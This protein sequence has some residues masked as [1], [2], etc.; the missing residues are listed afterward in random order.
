M[1]EQKA[2]TELSP[3]QQEAKE[4]IIAWYEVLQELDWDDTDGTE[5]RT[6][7][8]PRPIF[9]LHG[10]AGTGKT[11]TIRNII[12]ALG[13]NAGF[14]AYTGKAALVMQRQG[15]SAQTLHSLLYKPVPPDKKKCE[16]LFK[17]IK[18]EKSADAK[19]RLQ[20]ELK[21]AQQFTFEL[22]QI[23]ESAFEDMDLLVV[24]ECSMVDE[25]MLAD[26]LTFETPVLALGDPGQLPPVKGTGALVEPP[27]DALLTEI[28]RQAEGN[29]I[30]EYATCARKGIYIPYGE[31]GG[32]ARIRR[33]EIT[34][35]HVMACDQMLTG[36]N[37]SRQAIN[38]RYRQLKGF[39][40]RY[41]VEGE[42][43]ICLKNN[44][45]HGIF[46]GM[47]AEVLS[48]GDEYDAAI[49][50]KLK[51]ENDREI[52]VP[53]LRAYFDAYE[54]KEA[55]GAV[56]WWDLRDNEQFDFGYCI[57]V[58]K[59]QGSQWDQVLVMDDG[60]LKWDK[61]QRN[62][63]LYTAITRAAESVIIADYS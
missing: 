41:P 33:N 12:S 25:E 11:T 20:Q 46:N 27:V 42:K 62:R 58:H 55:L 3:G 29:P 49:V 17:Q 18:E 15:L 40:G 53:I 38:Q 2:P 7:D 56:K 26:I 54:D 43:L 14:A 50:Y 35:G 8:T 24:D 22:K 51:M 31:K 19:R 10:F 48:I 37:M 1:T 30:I 63:W 61:K 6:P 57:T 39:E 5:V 44:K 21:E 60:F 36:K 32:S 34:K 4:K 28:H 47:M 13:I 16:E 45:A 23:E 52:E 9:K 59:A